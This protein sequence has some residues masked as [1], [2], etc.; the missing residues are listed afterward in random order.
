MEYISTASMNDN[1]FIDFFE[2][3]VGQTIDEFRLIDKKQ[4]II[5]AASGGKDST[6]LLHIMKKFGYNVEALTVNAHIGCYSDKSLENLKKFCSKERIVLH[7]VSLKNEFGNSLCSIMSI[8]ENKNIKK[9]SCSICGTLRRYL[10]NKHGRRLNADV[11]LTGHNLDDEANGVLVSLFSGNLNHAARVGPLVSTN[12][13][14]SK[15]K[16]LY[17]C[18]EDEVE[19]YSKVRN[20][21]V[22]YGWCPCSVKGARRFYAELEISDSKRFNIVENMLK[23]IPKLKSYFRADSIALCSVCSEPSSNSVCQTCSLLSQ[24][25]DSEIKEEKESATCRT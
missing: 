13:F 20:F 16:P 8:L 9:T 3:K 14:I 11:I 5:V 7:E 6:V 2:G 10:L 4:K 18:F 23:N 24:M 21:D 22:H 12:G 19:R 25:Q 15:A 17:F 1:D